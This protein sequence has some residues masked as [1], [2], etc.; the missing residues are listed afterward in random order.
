[1]L[2][3]WAGF[4]GDRDR[5]RKN[6]RDSET[7]TETDI[8]VNF[9]IKTAEARSAFLRDKGGGGVINNPLFTGAIP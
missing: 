2:H 9:C 3:G 6:N 1:M 5:D 8:S 7:E 4:F